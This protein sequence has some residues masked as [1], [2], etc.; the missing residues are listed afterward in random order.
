MTASTPRAAEDGSDEVVESTSDR[1]AADSIAEDIFGGEDNASAVAGLIADF[2]ASW[3]RYKHEKAPETWLAEELRRSSGIQFGE[4]EA[5]STAREIVAAVERADADKVSLYAHL[6]AGRSKAS[7]IAGTIER[8]AAAA[9]TRA[10]G[11]YAAKIDEALGNANAEMLESVSTQGGTGINMNP[12]LDGF[13]AEQHHV[14]TFNL[15]AAAKNS[16]LRAKV[17]K[18]EAGKPF[19]K[20]SL[21]IG[22]Y[23]GNDSRP[24]GRYQAKY[25]KDA[26]ATERL[27]K[28]GGGYRGQQKLVPPEQKS[29]VPDST[30]AIEK[31]GVRSEP[32][33]KDRAKAMR[34]QVQR[35]GEARK[36]GWND[37]NRIEIAK[38]IGKQAAQAAAL[39]VAFQ[40]ARVLVRRVWNFLV[41]KE[42]P[43][44]SE[45]L[46]KFFE[47]SVRS[48]GHVGVQT[49]VSGAVVVAARNGLIRGLQA[50]PPGRIAGFVHVAMENARVL[51]K[52]ARGELN[53]EE[54]LDAMGNSTCAAVGGLVGAMKGAALGAA[55]GPVGVFVGGVV[56]GMA[57]SK[58]GEAVY[59]GGKAM[60]K[61]AAKVVGAVFEGAVETVAKVVRVLTPPNRFA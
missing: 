21:D 36:Y 40:G 20:N 19:G 54:A 8:G 29:D 23:K 41:G 47:S 3:E 51:F 2:V 14:D 35:D 26:K 12:N 17:L 37:V 24:I 31:D 18:P 34:E 50:T 60:V 5:L 43:P 55:L 28:E 42:N 38:S 58:I 57:G 44:P 4:E 32:L 7:W 15:D 59:E 22:I 39:A 33:S 1:E 9:G 52:F 11:D 56:G 45:D 53:G 48:A 13:I 10:V 30:D 25:G 16:P 27:F 49:A 6:D 61:R 46:R